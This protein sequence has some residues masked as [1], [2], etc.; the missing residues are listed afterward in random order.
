VI[1][2]GALTWFAVAAVASSIAGGTAATLR[3]ATNVHVDNAGVAASGVP[4]AQK[5]NT[6][7]SV[8]VGP[9]GFALYTLKGETTH[10]I[11][12]KKTT[13]KKTNCWGFWPPASVKS[14]SGLSTQSGLTGKLGTFQNQGMLQLTW[15]GQPLYY[16]TPDI[17]SKNKSAA[18]GAQVKTFGSVWEIVVPA[19]SGGG[20]GG[21]GGGG[22]G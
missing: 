6:H 14:A 7:E 19:G 16:F 12:C 22:W 9:T 17:T 10:H 18:S 1:A 8:V 20:G 13:N 2:V 3:I 15:N 4:V 21:G 11:I 5:V